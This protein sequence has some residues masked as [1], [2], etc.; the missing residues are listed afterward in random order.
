MQKPDHWV[1]QEHGTRS[2][3]A[4][5]HRKLILSNIID[6]YRQ[7]YIFL[8]TYIVFPE[9]THIDKL[10]IIVIIIGKRDK[11]E[12]PPSSTSDPNSNGATTNTNTITINVKFSGSTIP[13][14]ISPQSTI[15]DLKSLLLPATNVLPRGQKLIFKGT[16]FSF[17]LSFFSFFFFLS[18]SSLFLLI[19]GWIVFSCNEQERF[20]KTPWRW[21]HP[22]WV[23]GPSSCL[24]LPR[25]YIKGY[26]IFIPFFAFCWEC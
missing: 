11:M 9:H 23:M 24:W 25:V 5:W 18:L 12:Q 19:H 14:S 3:T 13:I 8:V 1:G 26:S 7:S 16:S 4:S 21:R 2:Q 15:K 6:R 20:W 10:I 22:A 17:T